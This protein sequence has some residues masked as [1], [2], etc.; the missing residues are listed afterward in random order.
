[1]QAVAMAGNALGAA[2]AGD[3]KAAAMLQG[4]TPGAMKEFAVAQQILAD[5]QAGMARRA[6]A[7]KL[8]KTLQLYFKNKV[9][10]QQYPPFKAS[11]KQTVRRTLAT[12][13]G[14]VKLG[15]TRANEMSPDVLKGMATLQEQMSKLDLM[16]ADMVDNN[17][18]LTAIQSE[19]EEL[20]LALEGLQNQPL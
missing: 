5:I 4:A 15:F 11:M 1:M 18:D 12:G 3:P 2:S 10:V 20:R 9:L 7:D 8:C 19:K 17:Q 16:M 13:V 14:Y 6:A